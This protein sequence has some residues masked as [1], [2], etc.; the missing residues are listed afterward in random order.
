[1]SDVNQ[2]N[3][4]VNDQALATLVDTDSFQVRDPDGSKVYRCPVGTPDYTPPEMQ[5][6]AFAGVNRKP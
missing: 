6:V 4:L 3:F 5:G 1:V 2:S